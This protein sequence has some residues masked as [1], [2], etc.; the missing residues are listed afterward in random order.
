MANLFTVHEHT[1]KLPKRTR[2]GEL[3]T[4]DLAWLGIEDFARQPHRYIEALK[5][6][7]IVEERKVGEKTCLIRRLDFGNFSFEDK[8]FLTCGREL[9]TQVESL[10]GY[11]ASYFSIR[12]VC[13]EQIELHFCYRETFTEGI[14]NN[15]QMQGIRSQA[16]EDKDRKFVKTI[17]KRFL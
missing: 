8:V 1:L 12:V 13:A 10:A 9:L 15:R 14:S 17:T 6:S 11:P 16:W 2:N 3:V 4:K 5:A 7:S